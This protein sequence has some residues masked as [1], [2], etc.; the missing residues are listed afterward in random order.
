MKI[1][2]LFVLRCT[3][4]FAVS[5]FSIHAFEPLKPQQ[6]NNSALFQSL[7]K[8]FETVIDDKASISGM[9]SD[10]TQDEQGFLWISG[11]R[12]IARFD[13]YK[14]KQYRHTPEQAN[15]LVNDIVSSL[16]FA[17][18]GLLWVSTSQ[19]LSI[20]D[21][22][23]EIFTNYVSND[24]KISLSFNNVDNFAEWPELGMW[25]GTLAGLNFFDYEQQQ[26]IDF[27]NSTVFPEHLRSAPINAQRV[28]ANGDLLF[29]SKQELWLVN[30][31][32]Y[33]FSKVII[34]NDSEV[35]KIFQS[36]SGNVWL[37]FQNGQVAIVN[38]VNASLSFVANNQQFNLPE[39]RINDFAEP[40]EGQVWLAFDYSGLAIIDEK[41]LQV[42]DTITHLDA[43]YG[44][45]STNLVSSL[46]VD[47]SELLWVTTL[48]NGL[49]RYSPHNQSFATLR[50]SSKS[51]Q[52]QTVINPN[53]L[54]DTN[55]ISLLETLDN[56]LW[57]GHYQGVDI[58]NLAGHKKNYFFP[59]IAKDNIPI[60][61]SA[62]AQDQS[63][64]VWLGA[65][66]QGLIAVN[67]HSYEVL[68]HLTVKDGLRSEKVRHIVSNSDGTLW[69]GS[70]KGIQHYDP[71]NNKFSD[72]EP[73]HDNEIKTRIRI[74]DHLR[75]K[76]GELIFT[77]ADGFFWLPDPIN[78]TKGYH[79]TKQN[80][81]SS[82][83]V[84][85]I[86]TAIEETAQG[87]IWLAGLEGLSQVLTM[88][89]DKVKV[90]YKPSS[91]QHSASKAFS[92]L[93]AD[94]TGRLWES[95]LLYDPKRD[96]LYQLEPADGV[97]IGNDW[98]GTSLSL[99]NGTL[100]F[101]GSSGLLFVWPDYF[102]PWS[103]QPSIELT[104]IQVDKVSVQ[105]QNNRLS[106]SN[107]AKGFSVE[108]SALDYSMPEK[109]Q[110]KYRLSGFDENWYAADTKFRQVNYTNLSPGTYQLEINATNRTGQWLEQPLILT[111]DVAAKFFQTSW[112][113]VLVIITVLALTYLFYVNRLKAL[114]EK[115]RKITEQKLS[116]ERVELMKE[117]LAEREQARLT[118]ADANKALKSEKER[119]ESATLAKSRFLANMSHEIRTPM[120]AILGMSYL[121]LRT[122]LNGKQHEYVNKIESAAEAL[123]LII[124]DILDL[125]KIE[126]GHVQ[127]TTQTYDLQQS[128]MRSVDLLNEQAQ[129]KG[130]SLRVEFDKALP[131]L[132]VG[133][134]GKLEQVLI[135]LLNNAI[136]FTHQ[137]EVCLDI[138]LLSTTEQHYQ[139]GFIV[140]D[141]GIGIAE[142]KLSTITEAFIQADDSI[143]R[144]YGGTGLGLKICVQLI[145]LMGGKLELKSEL[146]H[147]SQLSFNL[148]LK[149][150][151]ETLLITSQHQNNK[152]G[153]IANPHILLADD[154]AINREILETLLKQANITV[155][156]VMNGLEVLEKIKTTHY[157]VL[158]LDV[159]MP[160]MNGFE[161]TKNIRK[162]AK[163]DYLPII[164]VTAYALDTDKAEALKHGMTDYLAKPIRP[165][166][167]YQCLSK[168]CDISTAFLF[169]Q[170]LPVEETDS[171]KVLNT[172][173]GIQN[174][175][176]DQ[177]RYTKLLTYFVETHQNDLSN[178]TQY[179]A[180]TDIKKLIALLHKIRGV[181]GNIG[182]LHLYHEISDYE[183]A[184]KRGDYD[185]PSGVTMAYRTLFVE[186]KHW[187]SNQTKNQPVLK[188]KKTELDIAQ[189]LLSLEQLQKKVLNRSFSLDNELIEVKQHY[190][191]YFSIEIQQLQ[192]HIERYQF[193]LA[194][195]QLIDLKKKTTLL[196]E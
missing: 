169:D 5:S 122:P 175:G 187:L 132:V 3:F 185:V 20:F 167:L 180:E 53:S 172:V 151:D 182:A 56:E 128:V 24:N 15:S 184:V 174:L 176:G 6:L 112:F 72:F 7:P 92:N 27:P 40:V 64:K 21:P 138:N 84:A 173:K 41:T 153:K 195:Q 144:D 162:Q 82:S 13:G 178:M 124:N 18:N 34:S 57:V 42:S 11:Q 95:T 163:Y 171:H 161:A 8:Y 43:S 125:S 186:I 33:Q 28:L 86:I 179:K 193:N 76:N 45:L 103:Y 23:E 152:T 66:S 111:I 188:T 81:A 183:S 194:D 97:D 120:N 142:D 49:Q 10:I 139:I 145:E 141:T 117:R 19:G 22:K 75:L 58:F 94:S 39:D 73:Q 118:L 4:F 137:G 196:N 115:G 83:L 71:A 46:F 192:L 156:S 147:G 61:I 50:G 55:I 93:L 98:I 37:G 90:Q 191:Q 2:W 89:T 25:V 160:V 88:S 96:S 44:Q 127:L 77:S 164:A 155:D 136:K 91:G 70:Y 35:I 181:V 190:G 79:Y 54:T 99:S 51:N 63:G 32:T 85:N 9:L 59:A 150:T 177:Q 114:A 126:S 109:I 129:S 104:E 102:K 47:S 131:Q 1:V 116:L 105:A 30:R 134:N 60:S 101:G 119:A 189:C 14:I 110:Y 143:T 87:D 16:Y 26:F 166:L 36:S 130:L 48:G 62:M 108:F 12:G 154:H 38:L 121:T 52:Q 74:T 170:Q 113:L 107:Q 158:I 80:P 146:G 67:P 68:K 168:W 17:E 29:S 78:S 65:S 157:D 31:K 149:L 140:S 165:Q 133:D 100:A 69:I 135:N 106:L 148:D 123:L 159:N